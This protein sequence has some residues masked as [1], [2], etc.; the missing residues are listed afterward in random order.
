[1]GI[2]A[3]EVY[4]DR[5]DHITAVADELKVSVRNL[6]QQV[7]M[8]YPD[9][10]ASVQHRLVN[11]IHYFVAVKLGAGLVLAPR[12]RNSSWPSP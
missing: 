7:R 1:M 3:K 8:A 6:N 5:A 2:S 12:M 11:K 4:A 10:L 9:F